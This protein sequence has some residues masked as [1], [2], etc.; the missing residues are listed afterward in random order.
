MRPVSNKNVIKRSGQIGKK[1]KINH[2]KLVCTLT[3]CRND[4][5]SL[6]I[7]IKIIKKFNKISKF[8]VVM[9]TLL[10]A[11]IAYLLLDTQPTTINNSEKTKDKIPIKN[12]LYSISHNIKFGPHTKFTQNKYARIRI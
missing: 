2:L 10:A 6:K 11:K 8:N 4:R 3:I 12:K 9:T 1:T 5:D 7:K